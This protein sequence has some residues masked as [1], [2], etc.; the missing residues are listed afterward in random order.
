MVNTTSSFFGFKQSP[1][2]SA[3]LLSLIMKTLKQNDSHMRSEEN[4]QLG[5]GFKS[6][7]RPWAL[8]LA[9]EPNVFEDTLKNRIVSIHTTGA[10][11]LDN[12]PPE[13]RLWLEAIQVCRIENIHQLRAVVCSLHM[14]ETGKKAQHIVQWIEREKDGQPPNLIVVVDLLDYLVNQQE[15][16]NDPLRYLYIE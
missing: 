8:V 7:T 6:V 3:E 9:K 15:K 2:Y 13:E 1:S 16:L 10:T 5:E 11:A 4:Q 12:M 14:K